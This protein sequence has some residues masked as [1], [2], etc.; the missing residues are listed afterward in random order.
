L[1]LPSPSLLP[2]LV[3]AGMS[4]ASSSGAPA[5]K[6]RRIM[7][8]AGLK[9]IAEGYLEWEKRHRNQHEF[10]ERAAAHSSSISEFAFAYPPACPHARPHPPTKST[11][12]VA[13]PPARPRPVPLPANSTFRLRVPPTDNAPSSS[14]LV[15]MVRPTRGGLLP[16]QGRDRRSLG[17]DFARCPR[18]ARRE[19]VLLAD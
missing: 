15:V 18:T 7:S 5:D 8:L 11:L 19:S 1:R 14:V 17:G 3:V 9:D 13:S 4:T 10:S 6:R 16:P 2:P 12:F